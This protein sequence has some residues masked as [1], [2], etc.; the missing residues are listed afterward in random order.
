[1]KFVPFQVNLMTL[2]CL[3]LNFFLPM[4]R[5]KL[6]IAAPLAGRGGGGAQRLPPGEVKTSFQTIDLK[7]GDDI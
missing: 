1:M 6:F 3:H 2:G 5:G 4:L 7:R